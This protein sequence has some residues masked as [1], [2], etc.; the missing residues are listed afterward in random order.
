[1]NKKEYME[2]CRRITRHFK[3]IRDIADT[4][5]TTDYPEAPDPDIFMEEIEEEIKTYFKEAS[6]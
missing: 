4:Y 3:N 2:F 5:L 6:P 1:M